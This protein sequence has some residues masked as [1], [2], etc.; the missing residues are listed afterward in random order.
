MMRDLWYSYSSLLDITPNQ[1]ATS[2]NPGI[3]QPL[4]CNIPECLHL[5][6]NDNSRNDFAVIRF[7]NFYPKE[8]Q[9]RYFM[10]FHQVTSTRYRKGRTRR[11]YFTLRKVLSVNTVT[12]SASTSSKCPFYRVP[13]HSSLIL[14]DAYFSQEFTKL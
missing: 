12:V 11:N 3:N 10:Q 14:Y 4:A 13:E 6:R 1:L 5:Q 9:G 8:L 7:E 2:L